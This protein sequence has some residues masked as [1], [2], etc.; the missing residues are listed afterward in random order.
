MASVLLNLFDLIIHVAELTAAGRDVFAIFFKDSGCERRA[1]EGGY[2]L[3]VLDLVIRRHAELPSVHRVQ[4][5]AVRR[6]LAV[7]TADRALTVGPVDYFISLAGNRI[8]N[9]DRFTYDEGL[10]LLVGQR[11]GTL[12]FEVFNVF[13]ARHQFGV[14][15]VRRVPDR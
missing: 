4:V 15:R 12:G 5:F 8:A 13:S 1:A 7:D 3:S 2:Q 10:Q 6:R 14:F 11:F 9:L